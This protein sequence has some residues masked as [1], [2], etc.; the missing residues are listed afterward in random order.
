MVMDVKA[1]CLVAEIS[2]VNNTWEQETL[3]RTKS[4]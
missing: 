3:K 1:E 4:T 2:E